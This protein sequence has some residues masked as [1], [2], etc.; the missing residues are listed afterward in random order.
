MTFVSDERIDFL[1]LALA[2]LEIAKKQLKCRN[3]NRICV[4]LTDKQT[5]T[6]TYKYINAIEWMA[7]TFEFQ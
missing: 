1:A 3:N 5:D 4:T 2:R 7:L 6:Q